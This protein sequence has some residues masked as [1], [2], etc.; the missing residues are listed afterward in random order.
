[1]AEN[2]R[3]SDLE[4]RFAK[5][6]GQVVMA[7][8]ELPDSTAWRHI[9]E[10]LLRS[11]TASGAHY[12]EARGVQSTN[13]FIHKLSLALKEQREAVYW[14]RVCVEADQAPSNAAFLLEEGVE[15]VAILA[16]SL[17]TARR[18]RDA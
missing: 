5:F 7:Q 10:Q 1:M 15:L 18:N 13:D 12:G 16:A 3:G 9:R 17:R 4:R 2:T 8:G 11:G 14:T 6:G